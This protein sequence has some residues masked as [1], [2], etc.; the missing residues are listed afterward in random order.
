MEI[1]DLIINK[2]IKTLQKEDKLFFI[3]D[4]KLNKL[5]ICNE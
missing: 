3:K 4:E 5:E 1:L 2:R